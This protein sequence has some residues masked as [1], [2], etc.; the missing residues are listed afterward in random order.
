MK[1]LAVV[2]VLTGAALALGS[3]AAQAGVAPAIGEAAKA[4]AQESKASI[5]DEVRYYRRHHHHRR[6]IVVAPRYYGYRSY[7]RRY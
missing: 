5:V 2:A 4:V 6:F 1:K 7:G 3:L